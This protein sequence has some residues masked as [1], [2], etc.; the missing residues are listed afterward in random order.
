[1]HAGVSRRALACAALLCALLPAAAPVFAQDVRQANVELIRERLAHHVGTLAYLWGYPA[2][3]LSRQMHNETHRIAPHQPVAAPLNHFYRYDALIT[4]A[5]AGELRAPNSD[6]LYFGGWFDLTREPVVVQ[7]PDT[8]G[9]YYTLAVTDFFNEVTHLGRRTT[10]TAARA[11]ALV[12]PGWQ[13]ELPAGVQRVPVATRQAWILGRLLVDGE[14]DQAQAL[15]LMRGFWAA[16]LSAWRRDAP[17]AVP[18]VPAGERFEPMQTLAFFTV[19]NRWL[20]GN[21][22]RA[23]EA[24]LL[25]LFDQIGIGPASDFQPERLDAATRRGLE[26]ALADGQ[27]LLRA[28]SQRPLTDVRNGWI[29]P[30]GLADYGHDY[31]LRAAVAFGGYA[32]RPEETIYAA[33]TV[34]G[35]GRLMTGAGRYRLHFPPGGLPPA[36]AFW[37]LSAYDLQRFALIENPARRYSIGDRTPGLRLNA[38]GSLDILIQKDAPASE[39]A[40][41]LPVGEGAF[42]LVLRLYEPRAAAFDGRFKP[43]ALQRLP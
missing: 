22:A 37:S 34:D 23:D 9:R 41:W 1:M 38:D 7:A 11:F 8:A 28:H 30:L 21:A 19:L 5:T 42:S 12:G 27:A 2:V 31:L 29:F 17:P 3:D 15:A 25:G 36:D 13:G 20:R 35:E 18:P 39:Q 40:N 10:G 4:P 43:P 33:R 14:A 6:T 26:R 16:P 32:N 24:A